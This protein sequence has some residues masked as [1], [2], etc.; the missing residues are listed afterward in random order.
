MLADDW[1]TPFAELAGAVREGEGDQ[2]E[3]ARL[4]RP[5]FGADL[6]DDAHRLVP[7]APARFV[8]GQPPVEPEVRTADRGVSDADD[9]VG[10]LLNAGIGDLVDADVARGVKDGCS[11]LE[12]PPVVLL[13]D[14]P[15]RAL[16]IA[17]S[18]DLDLRDCVLD[19]AEIRF[20]QLDVRRYD[21]LLCLMCSGVLFR[22]MP[23]EK[24]KPNLVTI[25]T[26]SRIGARASPTSTSL[27]N[28]P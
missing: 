20:G 3:V 12:S 5:D 9:G 2:D 11:H 27:V 28:G 16:R 24:S 1:Q 19:L 21:V 17:S 15:L 23:S 22:A 8:G 25:T 10:R 4:D 7:D 13:I 18:L 26:S 6:L 14:H